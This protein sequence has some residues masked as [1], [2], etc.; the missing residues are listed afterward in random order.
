LVVYLSLSPFLLAVG[1]VIATLL[2]PEN[3]AWGAT[4]MPFPLPLQTHLLLANIPATREQSAQMA[5]REQR[6]W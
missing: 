6:S 5:C 3:R 1:F 2:A 4:V